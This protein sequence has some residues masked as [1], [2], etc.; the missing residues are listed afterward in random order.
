M[1]G[2][3]WERKIR[4]LKIIKTT[5]IH[6][7]ESFKLMQQNT[8]HSNRGMN[9]VCV[10]LRFSKSDLT[11]SFY[12]TSQQLLLL[13]L[14]FIHYVSPLRRRKKILS[15]LYRLTQFQ[16]S[17]NYNCSVC[18]PP[19]WK[20]KDFSLWEFVCR[21]HSPTGPG[22]TCLKQQVQAALKRA[23]TG[24]LL[25]SNWQKLTGSSG[26]STIF[27]IAKYYC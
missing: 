2:R 18:K 9:R 21:F 1:V 20:I 22:E 23:E 3:V 13:H 26:S 27:W 16:S 10:F 17:L 25:S 12:W 11:A 6:D 14:H 4:S 5:F 15:G 19:F 7:W 8:V 24:M